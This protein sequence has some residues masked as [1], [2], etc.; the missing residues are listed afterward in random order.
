[1]RSPHLRVTRRCL[2]DDLK[3]DPDLYE[4]DARHYCHEHDA[5]KT[6]VVRREGA[7]NTGEPI[8]DVGKT[9]SVLSL[10]VGTG[11]AAT[12]F[13]EE[14]DVCWLLAWSATHATGEKRDAYKHFMRLDG[15]GELMPTAED[16]EAIDTEAISYIS[17]GLADACS[18]LYDDARSN[19][20]VEMAAT[21]DNRGALI[22]VDLIVVEEDEIEEGW[23]AITYP[24]D[25]PLTPEVAL[26]L[27][28][29][30]LPTH[31]PASELSFSDHFGKRPM[32]PGELIFTWTYASA[33]Y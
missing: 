20:G 8:S 29:R 13:D 9:G 26:D 18:A 11:R 19:S 17:D 16:Y 33:S 27:S 12:I 32:E 23:I 3:V 22:L 30:I 28:A 21:F 6:F 2:E 15:R 5:L 10:H 4:R 31:I 7:P 25:T 24:R 14:T 1:M